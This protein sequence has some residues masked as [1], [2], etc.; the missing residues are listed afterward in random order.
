[1]Y[2]ANLGRTVFLMPVPVSYQN[3]FITCK[4]PIPNGCDS[5]YQR[6]YWVFSLHLPGLSPGV[7]RSGYTISALQYPQHQ[8]IPNHL[9][10]HPQALL[11]NSWNYTKSH[12]TSP[13]NNI[14]KFPTP[15][16][17]ST[18]QGLLTARHSSLWNESSSCP[19][20]LFLN[21]V[22]IEECKIHLVAL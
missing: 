6:K 2:H 9:H 14:W 19:R 10:I 21:L 22:C 4:W 13:H 11:H 1:M 3:N 8:T 7:Q 18:F 20:D 12:Q 15:Y 17:L 16:T 5:F